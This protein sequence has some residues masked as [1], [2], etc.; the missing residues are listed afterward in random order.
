MERSHFRRLVRDA[1]ASLPHELLGRVH[2][3]DIVIERR[4]SA[5]D[6]KMAGI[7][8]GRL[9][10]GLYHGVPLTHRGEN[11]NLVPPDKISIYQEPIEAICATDE[12]VRDQVRKTVLHELA[13][14]FGIDDDRLEELGLG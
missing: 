2:N 3:V 8:P 1:V 11:Y 12:E 13:H 7:G 6:R 9:L 4:P 5:M 10:L 14:Y